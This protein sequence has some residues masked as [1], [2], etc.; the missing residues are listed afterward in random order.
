VAAPGTNHTSPVTDRLP[1]S[2]KFYDAHIHFYSPDPSH[3]SGLLFDRLKGMGLAGFHAIVFT[4]FPLDL[5]KVLKM[6]PGA[7]HRYV[8]LRV[9]QHY[10]A[11]FH[12]F[13]RIGGLGIVPFADARFIEADA[14][15]KMKGFWNQGFRGLKLLYVPEEDPGLLLAGMEEAFG[16]T[17]RQSEEIT[18]RLID[19]AASRRMPV[20]FHADLKRYGPFVEEMI[21]AHPKTHF[22]IPHFGSSRKAMS[23]LLDKY[24]NCYTDL[25]SLTPYMKKEGA[26]YRDFIC[27]YQEKILFGSD[28][29]IGMPEHVESTVHFLRQLVDN[30]KIFYKLAHG[31][32]LNFHGTSEPAGIENTGG[33]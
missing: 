22:N 31:N 33:A 18:A 8:T 3:D 23:L 28:A 14:E 16:R 1:M 11:P 9:L 12:L 21:R 10:Q 25:S 26:S 2:M 24:V 19:A 15:Q 29:L 5:S 7:Y 27:Q 6:V 13:R 17:V 30:E 4:E 32:Y 20:L